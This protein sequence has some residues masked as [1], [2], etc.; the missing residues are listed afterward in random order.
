MLS[1]V[2]LRALLPS[3]SDANNCFEGPLFTLLKTLYCS[4]SYL[5][6][7]HKLEQFLLTKL[8]VK[9]IPCS[10]NIRD[11]PSSQQ[12]TGPPLLTM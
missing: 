8:S 9:H 7:Q 11:Q 12:C 3:I 10:N 5:I 2:M 1:F 4:T 6:V